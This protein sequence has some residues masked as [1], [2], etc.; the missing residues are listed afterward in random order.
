MSRP[1]AEATVRVTLDVSRFERE[2]RD[3]VQQAA[4]RAGRDF[5]RALKAQ[6]ADTARTATREFR[7]ATREGMIRAGRDAAGGF[8]V[9]FRQGIS[10]LAGRVGQ[11]LGQG[12]RTSVSRAGLDAGRGFANN[13]AVVLA[14]RGQY[15]GQAFVNGLQQALIDRV[16][17]LGRSAGQAIERNTTAGARN[18]GRQAA[19]QFSASFDIGIGSARLGRPLVLALASVA[20]AIA[21]DLGPATGILA[22]IPPLFVGITA[23]AGVTAAAVVGLSDAFSA[24]SDADIDDLHQAM[25]RLAPAAQNVVREFAAVRPELQALQRDIQNVFFSQLEGQVTRISQALTG[26]LRAGILDVAESAGVL[27]REFLDVIAS[28]RNLGNI[29]DAL[30]GTTGLFDELVPGIR[31]V[32]NG[33]LDFAGA[34]APGLRD[35]GDAINGLLE[36][37]G[38]WLSEAAQSGDALAWIQEGIQGFEGLAE[39]MGDI[40]SL[41]GAVLAAARPLAFA[42]EGLFDILALLA[43]IFESLPGPV[44]SLALAFILITRTGLLDFFRNVGTQATQMGSTIR[45]QFSNIGNAYRSAADPLRT[46]TEQQRMLTTEVG[47]A[48]TVFSRLQA[49]FG[50][51][52]SAAAGAGAA[53]RTGIGSAVSGLV[54]ALGGPW[55]IAISAAVVGL[56]L[57]ANS[58]ANA[59]QEAAKHRQEISELADTLN[60]QTGA[61]TDATLRLVAD[62]AQREGWLDTAREMG[63]SADQFVAALAG[64]ESALSNLQS[65]MA[66]GIRSIAQTSEGFGTLKS[67]LDEAGVSLEDWSL[68]AAGNVDAQR[69]L[70]DAGIE[71]ASAIE[72][73]DFATADYIE[74]LGVLTGP[75]SEVNGQMAQA[76]DNVQGAADAMTPAAVAAAAYQDALGVLADATA[77]ADAKAR[78]LSDALNILAGGTVSAEVAQGRFTELLQR[79]DEQL[80]ESTKGLRGMGAALLTNE[81]RINTQTQA[82]AFLIDTYDQIRGSLDQSVAATLEAGRATGDLQ[83]AYIRIA[84]DTQAARQQFIQTATQM[85]LTGQQANA[86]ADA[87]GL[88]PAQ[89]LT[90]VTDQ[91]SAQNVQLQILGVHQRLQNLPPNTPVRVEG[92]TTDAINKL[93]EVGIEV[94]TLPNGEVEVIARTESA[95]NSLADLVASWSGRVINF[96]ANIIGGNAAGGIM[97]NAKGGLVGFRHGGQLRKMSANRAEIVPPNTWRV[98][99]DRA[100]GD[101]AYIPITKSA[102]SRNILNATARRMGFELVPAGF[103]RRL[104]NQMQGRTLNVDEGAIQVNAPFADPELVARATIN[105]LARYAAS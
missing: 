27:S 23:A 47:R 100:V 92:L 79:L 90:T 14:D 65:T 80:V 95:R 103:G 83:G 72:G 42:M 86:L 20:T 38:R 21:S 99:G 82:G 88:I 30:R 101:E 56:G 32:T 16:G 41:L 61:I 66:E 28:S 19:R 37:F 105:E 24:I 2:L 12:L 35:I 50:T 34:A 62:R 11:R 7:N 98:I 76:R 15:A 10:Q 9:S 51:L 74:R 55:G 29:N 94:R 57:L 36:D 102:R 6:M 31:A 64:Q 97:P 3:K 93:R 33:I 77:D 89:V 53:L 40:V 1:L 54:G 67:T 91:G 17:N 44:Q 52:G 46:F 5:D 73:L 81:G 60:R 59:E 87:Y 69:R 63:I 18:A 96:V 26:E 68:A 43:N 39:T 22:G 49:G 70:R 71:N 25:Q 4:N 84:Q 13:V 75:L 8:D 85:G 104:E 58:Q 45:N 78:A 48:P